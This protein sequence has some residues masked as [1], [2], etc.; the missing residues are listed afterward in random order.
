MQWVRLVVAGILSL[1][2]HTT[3]QAQYTY[4]TTNGTITITRYTGPGGAVTIPDKINNLPVT[5]IGEWAFSGCTS[6]TSVTIPNSVTNI[7][8]RAFSDCTGL[9][10]VTIGTSVTSIGFAAFYGCTNLTNV[11]IPNSVT[12]IE[13]GAFRNC[14][15]L[16]S[17][18]IPNSVTSIGDGAFYG[19]GVKDTSTGLRV[20]TINKSITITG[21]TG[22]GGAVTIPDKINNL[23]VTN[24]GEWAFSGCTSLTS[25]TIPDSVT[26][27]GEGSFRG[28]VGLTHIVIPNN[29]SNIGDGAFYGYTSVTVGPLNSFYCTVDGVLF[30]KNQTMLLQYSAVEAG[31]YTI[32]NSVTSI[33]RGAFFSCSELTSVVIPDSV[34]NLGSSSFFHCTSLTNVT[35][36]NGVT[37]IPDGVDFAFI[38]DEGTFGSCTSLTSV[39]IGSSVTNIGSWAFVN[40]TSLT[41]ITIPDS[42][43]SIGVD[44]FHRCTSLTAVCFQGN[45][46]G[47]DQLPFADSNPTVYY[48]PGTKG[49]GTTF[50]GRPT[51]LWVRPNP[52]ILNGSL[53]IQ[54]NQ[55]GFTTSW[56][57]NLSVVVEVSTTLT[58]PTWSPVATNTLSGG[59]NYFS[60]PEWTNYPTRFYRIRSL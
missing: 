7:G 30:N 47:D 40:C 22:P 48:L 38:G 27:I 37:S 11:T 56:A 3:L 18:N 8:D 34:V 15:S 60:D 10:N 58:N 54:T 59:T 25:V 26:S 33:G 41:S 52:V 43:T 5:N 55:F 46:P 51:A 20:L 9:T 39:T 2:L 32:P 16:T 14:T 36:G 57:T 1:I 21:Y 49:W 50:S 31:G 45:P 29:V 6:L 35:I 28:C 24:I 19:S 23:P 53:G 44:V 42:V 17:I 4:I 12:S 13:D